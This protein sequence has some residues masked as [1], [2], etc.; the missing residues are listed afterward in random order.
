[1][2]DSAAPFPGSARP[3][4][5]SPQSQEPLRRWRGCRA[6][7]ARITVLGCVRGRKCS[8]NLPC[9]SEGAAA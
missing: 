4:V 5:R 3:A 6:R 1:L 7:E 2:T 8:W 9:C